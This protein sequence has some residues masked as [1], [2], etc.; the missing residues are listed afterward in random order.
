MVKYSLLWA[1]FAR[2][3]E[4]NKIKI[5]TLSPEQDDT[6]LLIGRSSN[7]QHS[8]VQR[9]PFP[10][11]ISACGMGICYQSTLCVKLEP[12]LVLFCVH[13]RFAMGLQ[14]FPDQN[15]NQVCFGLI[16]VRFGPGGTV[17]RY[18]SP[19]LLIE[20][21]DFTLYFAPYIPIVKRLGHR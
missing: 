16:S 21:P 13:L 5:I 15:L 12:S 9:T 3:C 2:N 7:W 4:N 20:N 8:C 1:F 10:P 19:C 11:Y 6:E 18:P 17:L 14:N